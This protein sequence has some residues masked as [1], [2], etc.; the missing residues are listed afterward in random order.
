MEQKPKLLVVADTYYPKVDGTLI[1]MEE[2][3]KRVKDDFEI[4]LLVPNY[5]VKKGHNVTYIDPSKTFEVSGYYNI[6]FSLKNFN[7]IKSAIKNADLVFIQGPALIS[8]LSIYYSHKYDKKTIFYTHTISWELFEKFFPKFLQKIFYRLIKKVSIF[9]YNKCDEILVPYQELKVNLQSEGVKTDVDV[10][11]LG[12]DIERFSP[13]KDK[14]ESKKKLNIDPKHQ[15]IGY[16]GRISKEKNTHILLEAFN[17][18]EKRKNLFLLMVGDG[19]KNQVDEFKKTNNCKVTGFVRNVD[20]YLKAM[21]VFVM[22]SLTETTSLA[23]LEAMSSGVSVVVTKIGFMKTY[24][25]KNHNGVFSARNSSTMLSIKIGKLLQ[26]KQLREKLGI[27]AR[28]TVAYSFSWER[29]IN[30]I[31]RLLLKQYY[32]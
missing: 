17:K 28:K 23:T 12:I 6:K 19:P 29:S 3:I 1:F 11:R 2:F 20:E 25:V 8:Y 24:I 4:S 18:L 30:R 27:N 31:K 22:P 10:A 26:N 13:P 32:Q 5:G 16:V 14:E 7:K 15:V 21:D 9:L